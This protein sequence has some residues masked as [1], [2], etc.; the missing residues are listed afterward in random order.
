M[1]NRI[2]KTGVVMIAALALI[3]TSLGFIRYNDE[4]NVKISDFSQK[5]NLADYNTLTDNSS[6]NKII[7]S[8]KN[9]KDIKKLEGVKNIIKSN[10]LYFV[11][12]DSVKNSD[13]AY[14]KLKNKKI[15]VNKDLKVSVQ[16][17]EESSDT[18]SKI[19]NNEKGT[20]VAVIDTGVNGAGESYDVTGEGTSDLSGHG[21]EMAKIIE[22]TSDNGANIISIK[23][24]DKNGDGSIASLYAAIELARELDVKAIN[25]S[26]TTGY[27][28]KADYVVD[29]IK[30]ATKSGIKV[31]CAAG[32]YS[33]DVKDFATAS[34]K[35]A[36]VVSAVNENGV[37]AEYSNYG[38]TV[39]YSA[40]GTYGNDSGTSISTARVTG[41]YLKYGDDLKNQGKDLGDEGWDKYFGN[42]TFGVDVEEG[43][44]P[45]DGFESVLFH[46]NWKELS[47]EEFKNAIKEARETMLSVW[48]NSLSDEELKLALSR[49]SMLNWEHYGF[50]D[51][52]KKINETSFASYLLSLEIPDVKTMAVLDKKKGYFDLKILDYNDSSTTTTLYTARVNA[53][54]RSTSNSAQKIT[55]T[56]TSQQNYCSFTG[57][58][59]TTTAKTTNGNYALFP[60]N[61]TYSK[62]ENRYAT[63]S[64]TL[65]NGSQ[66]AFYSS[67]LNNKGVA[68]YS[69]N[70][71]INL[72]INAIHLGMNTAGGSYAHGLYT[73]Y[74][75]RPTLKVTY[76]T[77]GGE[78]PNRTTSYYYK[79]GSGVSIWGSDPEKKGMKFA[80]WST[81]SNATTA[82]F[83]PGREYEAWALKQYTF[84]SQFTEQSVTLFAV[85]DDYYWT[86]LNFYQDAS[87]LL[88]R[89]YL[90]YDD[91]IVTSKYTVSN[92]T[93]NRSNYNG[94][95]PTREGA[96]FKGWNTKPDGSGN[97]VITKGMLSNGKINSGNTNNAYWSGG[98][99]IY[100]AHADNTLD[101]YP[102]WQEKTAKI[103]YDDN[104]S[105][106]TNVETLSS[107][108]IST[109]AVNKFTRDDYVFIGW[110]TEKDGSG[111]SYAEGQSLGH[112]PN[113]NS[114]EN[115]DITLYA[116]WVK[117]DYYK[118]MRFENTNSDKV[119]PPDYEPL[120][121]DKE[122]SQTINVNKTDTDQEP[123]PG[124][125]F[126][127]ECSDGSSTTITTDG[128]GK[129]IATFN[130]SVS[131]TDDLGKGPYWYCTN[132][133]ELND[134]QKKNV[135]N[136]GYYANGDEA[137]KAAE[138]DLD[139]YIKTLEKTY[140]VK[141]ISHPDY[142]GTV[143][144]ITFTLMGD[145]A[146]RNEN[147]IDPLDVEIHSLQNECTL[148]PVFKI[149]K[150]NAL[151]QA[152][153]G[154]KINIYADADRKNL[155]VEGTTD[156]NGE[157]S[158]E[159]TPVTYKTT[160]YK[161]V[162]VD[163]YGT[164][165]DRLVAYCK[166]HNL[167]TSYEAAMEAYKNDA[168]YKIVNGH[169]DGEN[170][171]A[172]REKEM[173]RTYYYQELETLDGYVLDNELHSAT[174][175][176][177]KSDD[178]NNNLITNANR[179]N[180]FD[181]ENPDGETENAG[182][183]TDNS[184]G[185]EVDYSTQFINYQEYT[186]KPVSDSESYTQ[187]LTIIKKGSLGN[188][189]PNATFDVTVDGN[190]QQYTTDTDGKISIATTFTGNTEDEYYYIENNEYVSDKDIN[191]IIAGS[192]DKKH[193]FKTLEE[194]Q[195]AM[196]KE[197]E[198]KR[199]HAYHIH[200]VTPP[201]GYKACADKS[202]TINYD[203][204]EEVDLVDENLASI[205]LLK[206][207]SGKNPMSN[208]VFG[209]YTT[210]EAYR[211]NESYSFKGDTYYLLKEVKTNA[212]GEAI[213]EGL[214]PDGKTKYIVIE[215]VTNE[216]KILL[217]E[218]I[219]VGTLPVILDNAPD[220]N[221]DGTVVESNGKY[222][223]FDITYT[224]TNDCKFELPRTGGTT[225]YWMLAGL[226][227]V[228]AGIMVMFRKKGE[229]N[230]K[231]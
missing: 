156:E 151:N 158:Y 229:N 48:L 77:N 217:A 29:A 50:D 202:I 192:T 56:Y 122:F 144:D 100:S 27:K 197:L 11:T 49:D 41:Y 40:L 46:G 110:N 166:K 43:K 83:L 28:I 57:S 107:G 31:I 126:E 219:E 165:S 117:A 186:L 218:P 6:S 95:A 96:K 2:R 198:G 26:A 30:E 78:V 212:D 66:A 99:W 148:T 200:E 162:D 74:L 214:N 14:E 17:N 12:F 222:H 47:D 143:D 125:V 68:G 85:Y 207:D 45:E 133:D 167:Y 51:E 159:G 53:S 124:T 13:N 120:S 91:T 105:N 72:S 182:S 230:A 208:A 86:T 75:H 132:Y 153:P 58:S 178:V 135:A 199:E 79:S 138:K 201:N 181:A 89:S 184:D 93:K 171:L 73:L 220:S 36:D 18:I 195:A 87:K 209:V 134:E 109:I 69:V 65:A 76:N 101:L 111:T 152:L 131:T 180:E 123:V 163:K 169:D 98:K 64:V 226:L 205:K 3:I 81:S 137:K 187:N 225:P 71:T 183:S 174:V 139:E 196:K 38:K 223:Y 60:F 67:G 121:L 203:G 62:P 23:A 210:D 172:S 136:I 24:F 5:I 189:L 216:G 170:P 70:E 146:T 8:A 211:N 116:Q 88:E 215:K 157:I 102:V 34:V 173:E 118:T 142:V 1:K 177:F 147:V 37:F 84:G 129:A 141:E 206:R 227:L 175:F 228:A 97:T 221:Y 19:T 213:V 185:D 16:D 4:K 231:K 61:F 108:D 20:R 21:T 103:T 33:S 54:I 52:G 188:L 32:N 39:D 35:E 9:K 90:T 127:I 168:N 130:Y 114:T 15:S 190:I 161:Y 82:S 119:I 59:S 224:V 193:Y 112:Y 194:A 7:V 92:T 113:I 179:N 155:L 204:S 140:T 176:W 25:L 149:K 94:T 104:F 63:Q 42:A 55:W 106:K 150:T 145:N 160:E 80:G 10:D 154:V 191:D 115:E 128:D 44:L 22:E 164:A